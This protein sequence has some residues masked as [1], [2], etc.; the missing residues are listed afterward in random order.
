MPHRRIVK[1]CSIPVLLCLA[2]YL[3]AIAYGV[4]FLLPS[5]VMARGADEMLAGYVISAAAISSVIAVILSGHFSDWL[6][7]SRAV[8]LSGAV[9]TIACIGFAFDQGTSW[10]IICIGLVL[11][12]GWGTFY[13]LGPL[14]MATIV[15][16]EQRTRGFG[17]LAGAMMAGIGT[18]PI[19]GRAASA[20]NLP[21]E[22]TFLA[23]G[24]AS[25]FGMA[26]F[27]FLKGRIAR[28]GIEEIQGARLSWNA[29][30]RLA[31]SLAC[32]PII[33]VGISGAIFGGL[34]SFQTSY[35]S[36]RGLDF[37]IYF[38]GFM[39]AAIVTRLFFVGYAAHWSPSLSNLLLTGLI[40]GC[41][42]LFLANTGNTALYFSASAMF[43]GGYGLFYSLINAQAVNLAPSGLV[44]QALLLFSLSYFLGA[45]G[46]PVIAA[47]II[48]TSG[49]DSL[50]VLLGVLGAINCSVALTYHMITRTIPS[51]KAASDRRRRL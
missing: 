38:I 33:M 29:V 8:I 34:S 24:I 14:L 9:L 41:I 26:M 48:V 27:A 45:F 49:I 40:T 11:G 17:M 20:A 10:S 50:L 32:Y 51:S 46:F 47:R 6:G 39:P 30:H 43:G 2:G 22:S 36:I 23:S 12:L 35:A 4:T 5:M 25:L 42:G 7:T 44:P 31:K 13:T 21:I 37:S 16:S 28:N 18:G 15:P 1:P 3:F 19:L